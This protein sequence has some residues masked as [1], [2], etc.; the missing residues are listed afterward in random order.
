LIRAVIFDLGNVLINFDHRIASQKLS[1]FTDTPEDEIYNLFFDSKL[2]ALFE[3]GKISTLQFFS[4]VKEALN[5]GIEFDEFLPIWNEIFFF[6]EENLSVY[7]LA[8]SLKNRYKVALLS[9]I[10]I[11]HFEHIKRTFPI[12]DAFHN[13]IT[14]F[15]M[16]FRKPN[17]EIYQKALHALDSPPEDV[18]YTDDRLELVES[19]RQLGIRSFIFKGPR[20]LEADLINSGVNIK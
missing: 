20:Q 15:E 4:K 14:S 6:D 2:T 19:A 1:K 5:L 9:N 18:F 17:P 13:I 7:N 10:N 16:G 11:S 12:L 8:S 3:E